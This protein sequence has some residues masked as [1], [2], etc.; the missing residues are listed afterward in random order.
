MLAVL[1]AIGIVPPMVRVCIRNRFRHYENQ[2]D[3]EI[4]QGSMKFEDD[5]GD[6]A[7]SSSSEGTSEDLH[8]ALLSGQ[9]K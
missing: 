4:A 5:W 1:S 9:G 3:E 2:L 7:M 8:E 6:N